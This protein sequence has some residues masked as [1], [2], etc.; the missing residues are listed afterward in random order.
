MIRYLLPMT[1]LLACTPEEKDDS[2]NDTDTTDVDT[3]SPAEN[4]VASPVVSLA[5]SRRITMGM[6]IPMM[7][8]AMTQFRYS[9]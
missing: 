7:S 8:T 1:L 2:T 5:T 6:A 4:P 9:S 3:A